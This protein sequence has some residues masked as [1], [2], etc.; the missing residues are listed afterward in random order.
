M[1]NNKSL[2]NYEVI[3][4]LCLLSVHLYGV[5]GVYSTLIEVEYLLLMNTIFLT[6]HVFSCRKI[7][8]DSPI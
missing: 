1:G 7:L 5:D 3:Y 4:Q 2:A 8:I 6:D